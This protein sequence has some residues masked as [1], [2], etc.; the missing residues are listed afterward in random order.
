MEKNLE[1]MVNILTSVKGLLTLAEHYD[2]PIETN[3]YLT[4]ISACVTK[5]EEIIKT[6]KDKL[7]DED[8]KP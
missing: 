4:M 6:T 1:E 7:Q 2:N 8:S 3:S 5:M